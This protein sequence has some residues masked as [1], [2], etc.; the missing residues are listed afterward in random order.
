MPPVQTEAVGKD[1]RLRKEEADNEKTDL[2]LLLCDIDH[3]KSFT[4]TWVNFKLFGGIGLML[5]FTIAQ[6]FYLSRY[7]PDEPATPGR[8]EDR[9]P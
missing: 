2:A 1:Q 9:T 5:V 3:F 8:A 6:G 7:L 4:D